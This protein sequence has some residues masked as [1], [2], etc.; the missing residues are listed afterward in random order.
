MSVNIANDGP[1]TIQ[2]DSRKF[3]YDRPKVHPHISGGKESKR[4]TASA[5]PSAHSPTAGKGA[6]K[7]A[8]AKGESS[9]RKA[10]GLLPE[11]PVAV[12]IERDSDLG[13]KEG[14][15]DEEGEGAVLVPS[16][17]GTPTLR[18]GDEDAS[19]TASVYSVASAP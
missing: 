2:L 4:V 3:E 7:G 17:V 9:D 18:V 16:N 14:E 19:E 12:V 13:Q 1:V 8:G 11:N 6:K 10:S 5:P 15:E